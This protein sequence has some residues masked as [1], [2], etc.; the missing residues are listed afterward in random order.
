MTDWKTIDTEPS[1]GKYR[2]YGL[3]VKHRNGH[4][5]F[6]AHYLA[7]DEEGVLLEPSG[8]IFSCWAFDDF[9]Y[10]ADAPAPPA[11]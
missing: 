6:E 2:F 4:R 5:W 9:E 7:L 3:I 10:W 8:D 1:D 11:L